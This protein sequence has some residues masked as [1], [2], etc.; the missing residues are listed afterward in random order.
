MRKFKYFQVVFI[1]MHAISEFNES[2]HT[3]FT[4]IVMSCLYRELSKHL[5]LVL[6]LKKRAASFW[7]S[8]TFQMAKLKIEWCTYTLK[9]QQVCC[10]NSIRRLSKTFKKGNQIFNNWHNRNVNSQKTMQTS[11]K[12]SVNR[13][14]CWIIFANYNTR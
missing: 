1:G 2:C 10:K 7:T 8:Q 3:N 9:K 4:L 12:P 14:S 13:F 11:S 5:K 6:K